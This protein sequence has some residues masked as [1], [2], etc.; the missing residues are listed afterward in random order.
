MK[1]NKTQI[2]YWDSSVF[3]ALLNDEPGRGEN[4]EQIIDE[5]EAGEVYIVTSS[6][7]LVEVIK[8]KGSIPIKIAAQK[9]VTEF[10]R[11]DYFRFVDATRKI[12]EAARDLIWASP[13]LNPK[14]AVHLASAIEFARK[15]RL[16]CIHSYDTD[17]LKL[18]GKLPI[19]CP[20]QEPMPRQ[21]T[22]GF[23]VQGAKKGARTRKRLIELISTPPTPSN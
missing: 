15:E 8:Y 6:F 3:V 23:G 17:F 5:A 14:D 9:T 19:S 11:K 7:T 18:S 2:F 16:D 20:V 4:L 21:R 22:F 13:S 10:F 1:K 12:T